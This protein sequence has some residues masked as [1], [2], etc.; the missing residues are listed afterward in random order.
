MPGRLVFKGAFKAS[1]NDGTVYLI[2]LFEIVHDLTA[3][4]IRGPLLYR[5]ADGGA[6][7]RLGKGLYELEESGLI[8]RSPSHGPSGSDSYA[9]T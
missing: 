1:A 9:A 7:K 6:V 5:T 2:D 3:D 8:L 4:Q